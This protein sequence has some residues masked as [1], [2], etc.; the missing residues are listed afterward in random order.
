MTKAEMLVH[1][2]DVHQEPVARYPDPCFAHGGAVDDVPAAQDID[3]AS[4]DHQLCTTEARARS[5]P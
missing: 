4:L 3:D 2:W 1:F 5:C